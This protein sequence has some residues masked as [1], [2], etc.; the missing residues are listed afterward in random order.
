M[1]KYKTEFVGEGD[2]QV[3]V[4]DKELFHACL[5]ELGRVPAEEAILGATASRRGAFGQ[6]EVMLMPGF[7]VMFADGTH[8]G[9]L[10]SAYDQ[11]YGV[12]VMASQIVT[13]KLGRQHP[14]YAVFWRDE[15][16]SEYK[17]HATIVD[18]DPNNQ[19]GRVDRGT[20]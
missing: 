7:Q 1:S 17:W 4:L 13:D 5:V 11:G 20:V 15:T 19:P 16:P 3:T 12:V 2:Q 9:A 14:Q 8:R 10:E 18:L 6:I